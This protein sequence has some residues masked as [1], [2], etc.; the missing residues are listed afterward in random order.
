M[1]TQAGKSFFFCLDKQ[2]VQ[3]EP[4]TAPALSGAAPGPG[5]FSGRQS[6][7][8]GARA[9]PGFPCPSERVSQI[10]RRSLRP[11]LRD[12]PH[13]VPRDHRVF[14]QGLSGVSWVPLLMMKYVVCKTAIYLCVV[15]SPGC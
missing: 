8:A 1:V 15:F 14:V 10:S 13:R 6:P 4:L 9:A 11:G 2:N 3:G 7:R 5:R 12:Q